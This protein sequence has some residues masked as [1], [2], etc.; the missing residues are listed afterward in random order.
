MFYKAVIR[1]FYDISLIISPLNKIVEVS[2]CLYQTTFIFTSCLSCSELTRLR[3]SMAGFYVYL[4]KMH[5]PVIV[6]NQTAVKSERKEA[7]DRTIHAK[8]KLNKYEP[9]SKLSTLDN[10]RRKFR[11][12]SL[13]FL[14]E[15]LRLNLEIFSY[16]M[17]I[18]RPHLLGL[19]G[20]AMQSSIHYPI[21][22]SEFILISLNTRNY[23]TKKI[24]ESTNNITYTRSILFTLY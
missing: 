15:C 5:R 19:H 18:N 11:H 10:S 6:I 3:L 16:K 17:Q 13:V 4:N 23:T 22:Y 20:P 24:E 1:G 2:K 12:T 14:S 9:K 8:V 7:A 21:A